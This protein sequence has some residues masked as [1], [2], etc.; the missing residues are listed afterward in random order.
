MT[1]TA[2]DLFC[3]AGGS[4]LGFE[5]AGG[6]PRLGINRRDRALETHAINLQHGEADSRAV[7]ARRH[8]G[9]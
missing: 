5:M 7:S 6:R 4:G 1:V 9:S 2:D 3:G 8:G